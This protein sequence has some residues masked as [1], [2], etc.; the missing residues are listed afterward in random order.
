MS[1]AFVLRSPPAD[2]ALVILLS[3]SEFNFKQEVLY[4]HLWK[5]GSI[6]SPWLVYASVGIVSTHLD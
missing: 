3:L 6:V 1:G 4:P 5:F 2:S